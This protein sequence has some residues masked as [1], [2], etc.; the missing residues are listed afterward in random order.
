MDA[1]PA[2]GPDSAD[3]GWRDLANRA[4]AGRARPRRV[5]RATPDD[6]VLVERVR[7]ELGRVGV[8]SACGRGVGGGLLGHAGRADPGARGA[9]AAAR[10]AVGARRAPR[11]ERARAASADAA[12][13]PALQGG[14]ARGRAASCMQAT[15]A[16]GPRLAVLGAGARWRCT[17]RGRRRDRHAAGARRCRA[18]RARGGQQGLRP[19]LGLAGDPRSVEIEKAIRIAAPREEVYALWSQCDEFPRSCRWS[20]RC[21]GSTTTRWHWVVKGPAGR[22]LEWDATVTESRRRSGSLAQRARRA[23]AARRLRAL[24]RGRLRHPRDGAHG[25]QPAG[26]GDRPHRRRP[27]RAATP[28]AS[29]TRT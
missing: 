26:R 18:G 19:L 17:A 28:S 21:G 4:T 11:Q 22:R 20:R 1:M 23:R 16:P 2:Q 25:L 7:A 27:L 29:S 12:H 8:A 15:W 10:G 9:A 6:D 13:V 24:R 5:A 14:G 3:A